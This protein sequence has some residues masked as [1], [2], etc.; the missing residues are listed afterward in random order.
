MYV[1]AA[2]YELKM[3][4]KTSE[5]TTFLFIVHTFYPPNYI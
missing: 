4:P 5:N 2:L 1:A 3:L